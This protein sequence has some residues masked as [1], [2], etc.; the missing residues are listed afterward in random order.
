[1]RVGSVRSPIPFQ[2]RLEDEVV[3]TTE[4]IEAVLEA[5]ANF[6]EGTPVRHSS[7]S[8]RRPDDGERLASR[9]YPPC[10]RRAA[11]LRGDGRGLVLRQG[12]APMPTTPRRSPPPASPRWSSTTATWAPASGEPRQHIDPWEQIDDYRNAVSLRRVSST[13]STPTA[14]ACGASPTAGATSLVLG[15]VDPRVR[16]LCGIVPVTD[17]YEN[18]RLAHGTFGLRR[19][20]AT[21]LEA[22]RKLFAPANSPTSRIS[23]TRRRRRDLALPEE[24]DHLRRLKETRR[25]P[26]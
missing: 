5:L 20:R 25:P 14:S 19:L 1:M 3:P 21:L 12:A 7:D 6:C 10:R 15:A 26:T 9:L 18:M 17:G 22:R 2:S 4:R 11:S 23:P 16:A 24:P 8:D 13:S